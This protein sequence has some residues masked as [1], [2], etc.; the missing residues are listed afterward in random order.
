[1]HLVDRPDLSSFQDRHY[2]L[3]I[4][5]I[6]DYAIYMLDPAGVVVSW[7]TGAQRA[8]GYR[9]E[10]IVGE[11]FARFYTEE[12]RA[13][14]EPDK[15]LQIAARHGRFEA[16]GWRMRRDGSRFWAHVIVDPI[17]DDSGV[18]IGFAKITRDITA[19]KQAQD[20]LAAA[21]ATLNAMN[22]ATARNEARFRSVVEAVP[23]AILIVNATGRIELVNTKTEQMFGY[24]RAELLG[25]AVD[26]LLPERLR[27]RHPDLR[28]GRFAE[29]IR[30]AADTGTLHALR[31]DGTEFE[32]E[33][34]LRPIDIDQ[35]TMTLATIVDVSDRV[36]MEARLRQGEK[37]EIL[38]RLAAGVSHDFNNILQV[39]L[40]G[41]DLLKDE[42]AL[43]PAG[44]TFVDMVRGSARRGASLTHHLLAYSRQQV[45]TPKLIDLRETLD[46][47]SVVL[48]R[49]LGSHIAVTTR[50]DPGVG[51]VR[52]DSGQLETALMNLAINGAHAMPDGGG[53]YIEARSAEGETFGE[54]KHGR[55]AVISVTDSGT[56]MDPKVLARV[57]DPFFTTKGR[58]GTGLGLSMVH[59]FARQ[60]GGD[61]RAFSALGKGSRFEIWLPEDHVRPPEPEVVRERAPDC[62]G[63]V[64]LVDDARDVLIMVEAFLRKA[65]FTVQRANGGEQALAAI[66]SGTHFD[67]LI[68][69]YMMPRFSGVELIRRA[70]Q[71]KPGLPALVISGYAEATES[72]AEMEHAA[73]LL[74][75][76][77]R[78]E[79][80]ARVSALIAGIADPS[81]EYIA[82]TAGKSFP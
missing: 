21:N 72:I 60:S 16:E 71:I 58:D 41:V 75:P 1:M 48:T 79:L 17:R 8:K 13:T 25:G 31:R 23:S 62:T 82:G 78:D 29:G 5:S 12:D 64:L 46:R 57:F 63:H 36:R 69:D 28:A 32:V 37:M 26:R 81:G 74:K 65:R 40:G 30:C 54:I 67:V 9:A 56:G 38:G 3:L 14:G 73:L 70:R 24:P 61:V 77:D 47:L 49:T 55:H 27:E 18:L 15:T 10:E 20:A 4:D 11:H 6:S 52:A 43:S 39:I 35:H 66:A 34:H 76:F 44:L 33:I 68:T 53:L 22:E 51:Q 19:V 80:T 50:V 7:N 42:E 2:R 45:Q 59:G